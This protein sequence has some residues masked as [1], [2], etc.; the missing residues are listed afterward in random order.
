MHNNQLE[1]KMLKQI[2]ISLQSLEWFILHGFIKSIVEDEEKVKLI[3]KSSE[4]CAVVETILAKIQKQFAP[5]LQDNTEDVSD[6]ENI[7]KLPP[8]KILTIQ[9]P[10]IIV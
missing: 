9:G 6:L 5:H 3:F 2:G 8:K 1:S 4:D 10:K 7:L